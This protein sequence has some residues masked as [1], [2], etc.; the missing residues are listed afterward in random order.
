MVMHS[1][2]FE[3]AVPEDPSAQGRATVDRHL[4]L[5]RTLLPVQDPAEIVRR[6]GERIDRNPPAASL[7]DDIT[8]LALH[9][10]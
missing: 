10:G 7:L 8:V 5:F 3:A 2:G 1:D 4:D 9:V 6:L